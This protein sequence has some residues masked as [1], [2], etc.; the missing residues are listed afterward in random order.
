MIIKIKL[1]TSR[2]EIDYEGDAS[3]F[4]GEIMAAVA[5]FAAGPL[6]PNT[7]PKNAGNG[8]TEINGGTLGDLSTNS[9]AAK[10]GCDSGSDL[11]M[12]AAARLG[13]ALG[14]STFT[15]QELIS[16][17]KSA[18]SYFKET[19]V[20]GNLTNYLKRLSKKQLNVV[21]KDVFSLAEAERQTLE[22]RLAGN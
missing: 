15:R 22:T 18:P 20:S 3:V 14:K 4:T 16:E 13:I 1:K 6:T 21:S 10:L 5:K 12:A 9:I 17:M 8:G 19:Y 2:F 7:N 11:V